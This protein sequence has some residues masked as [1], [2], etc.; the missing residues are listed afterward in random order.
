MGFYDSPIVDPSS[1]RSE[2][3]VTCIKS[4]FSRKNGF[5]A[6]DE[7]PDYGV[8]LEIELIHDSQNASGNKFSIQIKSAISTSIIN[9]GKYISLPFETSRLGYLCQKTPAYGLIVLYDSETKNIYWDYVEEIYQR[10]CDEK[11]DD[12]WRQQEDVNIH[13]PAENLL[14]EHATKCIHTKMKKRFSNLSRLI[15]DHGQSYDIPS[16]AML[17]TNFTEARKLGVHAVIAYIEKYGLMLFDANKISEIL[18]LLNSLSFETTNSNPKIILLAAITYHQAG[19]YLEADLYLRKTKLH[20]DSYSPNEIEILN[21][22]TSRN[23]YLLGELSSGEYLDA[24]AEMSQTIK[25]SVNKIS[26]Q[27]E[28]IYLLLLTT[29]RL[30]QRDDLIKRINDVQAELDASIL[31]KDEKRIYLL[32]LSSLL[33]EIGIDSFIHSMYIIRMRDNVGDKT[34]IQERVAA[35]SHISALLETPVKNIIII[36]NE[37]INEKNQALKATSMLQLSSFFF[38][39]EFFSNT[40]IETSNDSPES[41]KDKYLQH[42]NF[43]LEAYS[44]YIEKSLLHESFKS[45]CIAYEIAALFFEQ[46]KVP[47]SDTISKEELTERIGKLQARIGS[48]SFISIVDKRAHHFKTE[49]SSKEFYLSLTDDQINDFARNMLEVKRLPEERLPYILN[50]I[51]SY[52]LFYKMS[53]CEKMELLQN[54][55][56]QNS[57]STLYNSDMKYI[58]RCDHCQTESKERTNVEQLIEEMRSHCTLQPSTK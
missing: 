57:Q 49:P 45:L 23:K 26:I 19:Q 30:S 52:I 48:I 10:I 53:F 27:V 55:S 22:T 44:I 12:K 43:C 36:Y 11:K 40:L 24:L 46:F 47:I 20:T 16:L 58:I 25:S 9:E 1:I 51:K 38:S 54:L 32:S 17:D 6:R 56:H 42:F 39:M 50:D 18:T 41:I 28:T 3:S 29:P 7:T 21:L 37:S 15:N 2:E 5:I 14:N 31:N 34:T 8:D 4:I 35:Y 13:F 33:F